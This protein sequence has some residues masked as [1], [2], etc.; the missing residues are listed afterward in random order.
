MLPQ[1]TNFQHGESNGSAHELQVP[2]DHDYSWVQI[3][4][5]L[6]SL[7]SVSIRLLAA[8]ALPRRDK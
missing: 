7:I 5:C 1:I 4:F 3:Q 2:P 8:A 6:I